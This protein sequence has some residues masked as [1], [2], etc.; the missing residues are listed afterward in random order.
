PGNED[1]WILRWMQH[2][3]EVAQQQS[4]GLSDEHEAQIV[5]LLETTAT[6]LDWMPIKA[7]VATEL[8]PRLAA[9]LGVRSARVRQH[10]A[11]A[12]EIVSR[13]NVPAGEER[14]AILLQFVEAGDGAALGAIAQA[15]ATTLAPQLDAHWDDAGDALACARALAQISANLTT[16][17]WAR[18][19]LES[20]VVRQ[21]ERLVELLLALSRDARHSVSALV[22]PSW[23]AVVQHS[24]LS[25]TPQVAAAFS[26]LTEHTTE[27]IFRVCRAAQA[28]AGAGSADGIVDEADA[29]QFDSVG[30]L[31][32]FLAGEVRSRLLNIVRGMCALDPAGFVGWIMPSLAPALASD[33]AA[34]A[35]AAL[36]TVEAM[37]ATLDDVEQ[38]ALADGDEDACA[39]VRQARAPCY[40]LG[41]RVVDVA[42]ASAAACVR[43]LN[44]L[45]AFAFLLRPAAMD[46][47][48]ARGLLWAILQKCAQYLAP[49][50]DAP[51]ARKLR[52]VAR[53]ATAA[54][55][56]L[57]V[58]VPDSLMLVYDDLSQLVR[59]RIADAAVSA[60]IKGHLSEFLL[61]LI[62]GAS[63]SL[64]QRRQLARPVVQPL[65]DA[66]RD[67]A[68]ALQQPA[69]FAALLGLPALDR[70]CAHGIDADT[71]RALL[72]ARDARGRVLQM[73][74]TLYVCLNR[75]LGAGAALTPL[76]SECA[77]ELVPPLL[78]LARCLH[79][80]WSPAARTDLP[81]ESRE[82][83][84][85]LFGV[86]D[87]SP[88]ERA[89]IVGLAADADA[90]DAIDGAA[91][92]QLAA[93]MNAVRHALGTLRE[94][95]YKCIGRLAAM[96]ATF[97]VA[98]LPANFAACLFADA[99]SLAARHWRFLLADVAAPVLMHVGNWPGVDAESG[100]ATAARFAD[101]WLRPLFAFCTRCL[102]AE[103]AELLARGMAPAA[104][105]EF[106]QT[107]QTS[108]TDEIVHERIVR[109][110][111]R[112]WSQLVAELLA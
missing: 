17:H 41:R 99:E 72:A 25:R 59:A 51:D 108:V 56:R 89:S 110:W 69:D 15:Y 93:E 86:L 8:V 62:A 34:V 29:E 94:R 27:A 3:G 96:P 28:L 61:A 22:L 7:V 37:L 78:L 80:L 2:A 73:L 97:E 11:A 50:L 6:F 16:L 85:S 77:P 57:A 38:R 87:M 32:L 68:P 39:R 101:A 104:E 1:G 20:N 88:A 92:V 43:Q 105:I 103:W 14:D 18:K 36:M 10:A 53:R 111:T 63:C 9:L 12:L 64:A 95:T 58:A 90:A 76:W 55:V 26:A 31:R 75:T 70:A 33:D 109:D 100:R 84:E 67:L 79:A 40:E 74:S 23:A 24:V 5:Q 91:G 44:T 83:R 13:R 30:D 112:A 35:E 21:P 71:S 4:G 48:E 65:L 19:K 98:D 66:L 102:D 60:P 106:A 82:A 49:A 107:E 46:G 54:L 52:T 45:P 42:G 47:D 81:W